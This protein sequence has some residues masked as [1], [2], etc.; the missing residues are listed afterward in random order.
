MFDLCNKLACKLKYNLASLISIT[1][2]PA[3]KH[4]RLFWPS[5]SCNYRHISNTCSKLVPLWYRGC[6]GGIRVV[7]GVQLDVNNFKRLSF[8]ATSAPTAYSALTSGKSTAHVVIFITLHCIDLPQ[9]TVANVVYISDTC[10]LQY[11]SCALLLPERVLSLSVKHCCTNNRVCAVWLICSHVTRHCA[12]VANWR[13]IHYMYTFWTLNHSH[14]MRK[15]GRE[16]QTR[17]YVR[18]AAHRAAAALIQKNFRWVHIYIHVHTC[19]FMNL[20][21]LF[22]MFAHYFAVHTHASNTIKKCSA[23]TYICAVH[24]ELRYQ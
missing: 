5:N 3:S 9:L 16:L 12:D 20:C 2:V 15:L 14:C 19:T 13:G 7:R 4:L 6:T 17:Y 21:T 10:R 1:C 23:M 24:S 22:Y 8:V 18:K 11:Q